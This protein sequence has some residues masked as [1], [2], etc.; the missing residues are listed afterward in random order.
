MDQDIKK[1]EFYSNFNEKIKNDLGIF[2]YD[3]LSEILPDQDL[4]LMLTVLNNEKETSNGINAQIKDMVKTVVFTIMLL[5]G[6]QISVKKKEYNDNKDE[7]IALLD[8]IAENTQKELSQ[9]VD[10]VYEIYTNIKNS[11]V[12]SLFKA[13]LSGEYNSHSIYSRI[14][15]DPPK[16]EKYYNF[17]LDKGIIKKNFFILYVKK[18]I[19]KS[20]LEELCLRE[21]EIQQKKIKSIKNYLEKHFVQS[22]R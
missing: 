14:L 2:F 12:W 20:E 4:R 7:L 22:E 10:G 6:D 21:N 5:Y 9:F 1:I 3:M 11:S 15:Q 13:R 18:E 19:T 8:S 17:L 16:K